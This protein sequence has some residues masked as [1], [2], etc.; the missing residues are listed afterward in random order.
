[1]RPCS[2]DYRSGGAVNVLVLF[3][4]VPPSATVLGLTAAL[5]GALAT[6]V[7]QRP[8]STWELQRLIAAVHDRAVELIILDEAENLKSGRGDPRSDTCVAWLK[9]L[10]KAT[11]TPFVLAGTVAGA[12]AGI[13]GLLRYDTHLA[14]LVL[15]HARL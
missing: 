7:A 12:V 1:M 11:R 15:A 4:R 2:P 9:I 10:I 8:T 13:E 5:L 3:A 14:R 6:P